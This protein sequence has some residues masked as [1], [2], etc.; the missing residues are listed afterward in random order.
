MGVPS[1]TSAPTPVL[2]EPR[3]STSSSGRCAPSRHLTKSHPQILIMLA[4]AGLLPVGGTGPALVFDGT[5]L[6]QRAAD[7]RIGRSTAYRYLHEGIDALAA[8][9]PG[10]GQQQPR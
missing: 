9:H 1:R 8:A 7:S 5:R 2:I 3:A 6:A 4:R 10:H